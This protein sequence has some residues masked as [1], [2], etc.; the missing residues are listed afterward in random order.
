MFDCIAGWLAILLGRFQMDITTCLT[1]WYNLTQS[2]MSSSRRAGYKR[3]LFQGSYFEHDSLTAQ[4]EWLTRLYGTGEY[5]Y[6]DPEEERSA[7]CQYVFVAALQADFQSKRLRSK[8]EEHPGK[9]FDHDYNLFRSYPCPAGARVRQGPRDPERFAIATAFS[10]T[11]AAKYFFKPWKADLADNSRV[12]F[13]DRRFPHPHNVTKL[14]IDEMWGLRG[15]GAPLDVVVN[16]GPGH[17]DPEDVRRLAKRFSWGRGGN[18]SP[19]SFFGSRASSHTN[20]AATQAGAP[21]ARPGIASEALEQRPSQRSA[22][23]HTLPDATLEQRL[24][25]DED[26]IERDIGEKL[27]AAYRDGRRRYFRLAPDQSPPGT[28]LNDAPQSG[29]V[30][31]ETHS[32]MDQES[33]RSLLLEAGQQIAK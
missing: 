17:P 2:I 31:S 3:R 30:M 11:A 20:G 8:R 18:A 29:R 10:V 15:D 33:V 19:R 21:G 24:R 28:P 16:V 12:R 6:P 1:E 9:H 26:A 5:M 23:F 14:A 4:A 25:R 27:E 7:R 32:Y 22:T 13:L